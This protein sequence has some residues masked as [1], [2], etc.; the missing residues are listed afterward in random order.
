MKIIIFITL[1]ILTMNKNFG[2]RGREEGE[3]GRRRRDQNIHS[4][5]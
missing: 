2:G 4:K 3:W 5:V 1:E